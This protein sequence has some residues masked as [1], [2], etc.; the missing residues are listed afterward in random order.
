MLLSLELFLEK[1]KTGNIFSSSKMIDFEV[2]ETFQKIKH[3]ELIKM[4]ELENSAENYTILGLRREPVR[5]LA[6]GVSIP[7]RSFRLIQ[8]NGGSFFN[9]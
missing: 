8:E 2:E 6:N 1:G 4:K 7:L 9:R 5:P 3:K